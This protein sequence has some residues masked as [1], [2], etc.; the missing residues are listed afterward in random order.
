[1]SRRIIINIQDDAVSDES[2]LAMV[3]SV[4]AMGKLSETARRK[5]Y[6]HITTFGPDGKRL[7]HATKRTDSTDTFT[8]Q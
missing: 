4:V 8:I 7:V 1:M 5:H 6:C 3:Q 2:A